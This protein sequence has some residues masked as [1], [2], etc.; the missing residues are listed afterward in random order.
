M[1]KTTGK[2]KSASETKNEAS[3]PVSAL[4]DPTTLAQQPHGQPQASLEL[5]VQASGS[6]TPVQA[7]PQAEQLGSTNKQGSQGSGKRKQE[8]PKV[9]CNN[10]QPKTSAE[11]GGS[12]HT[13]SA[14]KKPK[15]PGFKKWRKASKEL[16]AEMKL[17]RTAATKIM[18]I[19]EAKTADSSAA[20]SVP[21]PD[22]ST[23]GPPSSAPPPHASLPLTPA[24]SKPPSALQLI[25]SSS[26]PSSTSDLDPQQR[27]EHLA[28]SASGHL[29]ASESSTSLSDQ[30]K[31]TVITTSLE[32]LEAAV[33]DEGR[34]IQT[35]AD[36]V[37]TTGSFQTSVET[38]VRQCFNK[39][40]NDHDDTRKH[41]SPMEEGTRSIQKDVITLAYTVSSI[42]SDLRFHLSRLD[43]V[44]EAL[45]SIASRI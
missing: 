19:H 28:P 40:T 42:K 11:S 12:D 31:S 9:P 2:G 22:S 15:D 17:F 25:P 5:A 1:L 45:D 39:S 10:K 27:E 33:R 34:F 37:V 18:E 32:K 43:H 8:D 6:A 16:E 23:T 4:P 29:E 14:G 21:P 35:I 30:S 41:R 44:A 36:V 24:E 20:S 7:Q 13:T 26:L 3:H 38:A